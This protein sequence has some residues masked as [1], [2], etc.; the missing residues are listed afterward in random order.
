MHN[1][2]VI[3]LA[4]ASCILGYELLVEFVP[5]HKITKP[6]HLLRVESSAGHGVYGGTFV[7]NSNTIRH[8]SHAVVELVI[9]KALDYFRTI[10]QLP[11]PEALIRTALLNGWRVILTER[12]NQEQHRTTKAGAD[13]HG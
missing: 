3:S 2:D 5:L 4:L 7:V 8:L 1:R 12:W 11:V 9:G 13:F 6:D 10:G